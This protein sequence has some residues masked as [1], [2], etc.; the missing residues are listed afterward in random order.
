M[1]H[2]ITL[3]DD[4]DVTLWEGCHACWLELV[5]GLPDRVQLQQENVRLRALLTKGGIDAD[6]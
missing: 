1:R 3:K 6:A 2:N 4:R 5:R